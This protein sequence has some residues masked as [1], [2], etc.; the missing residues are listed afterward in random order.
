MPWIPH[1]ELRMLRFEHGG[2]GVG[3]GPVFELRFVVVSLDLFDLEPL[4]PRIDEPLFRSFEVIFDVALAADVGAHLLARRLL[5]DIVVL[6]ALRGLER[7]DAFDETGAGDAQLHGARIVTVDAGH[8]MRDQLARFEERHLIKL[9]EACD[10]IAVAR[11]LVGDVDRR[12][13]LNAGAG[14]FDHLLALGVRL[15]VEHVSVAA[16]LAKI[17]GKRVSGPHHLQTRIFLD[18][19]LGDDRARIGLG[20]RARLG[21]AA[22]VAGAHLIHRPFVVVILQRKVFAPDRRV[23]GIVGQLDH[24]IKRIA[25]LLFALED[26]HQ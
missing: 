19:R 4:G 25:R 11:L 13:A 5:V 17:F 10:E 7:A 24:P 26:I 22:A 6:H 23:F 14:L 8:R 12:V 18:L 15:V 3:V 16:L 21:F 20:R 2:A 9:L 1:L